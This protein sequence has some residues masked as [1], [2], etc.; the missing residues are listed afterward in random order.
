MEETGGSVVGM[1]WLA[2][3]SP[4]PRTILLAALIPAAARASRWQIWWTTT[5]SSSV[6][7]GL[8]PVFFG[9]LNSNFCKPILISN[10]G[11]IYV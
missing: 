4:P 5:F 6:A 10:K 11:G 9:F 2:K 7:K 1:G 8:Y 3:L